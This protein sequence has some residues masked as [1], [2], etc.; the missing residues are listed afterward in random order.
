MAQTLLSAPLL[1]D[2]SRQ[3]GSCA[4]G[5]LDCVKSAQERGG[6]RE[7]GKCYGRDKDKN[8]IMCMMIGPFHTAQTVLLDLSSKAGWKKDIWKKSK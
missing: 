4:P 3:K 1:L 2:W 7:P 6:E 5:Y 8:V